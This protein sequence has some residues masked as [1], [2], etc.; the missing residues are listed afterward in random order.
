MKIH[1]LNHEII[2]IIN[3]ENIAVSKGKDNDAYTTIREE[4][5]VKNGIMTKTLYMI[6][7]KNIL[8]IDFENIWL[9]VKIIV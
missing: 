8:Y 2:N 4:K 5:E 6:P 9:L 7:V 3:D 1:L